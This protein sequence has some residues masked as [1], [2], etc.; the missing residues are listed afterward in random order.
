[1]KH[2]FHS[3]CLTGRGLSNTPSRA[4]VL[5]PKLSGKHAAAE[6]ISDDQCIRIPPR[7]VALVAQGIDRSSWAGRAGFGQFL[8]VCY[9][10]FRSTALNEARI[11]AS[12]C[13]RGRRRGRWLRGSPETNRGVAALKKAPLERGF[14]C[15]TKAG[16][17]TSV[18]RSPPRRAHPANASGSELGRQVAVDFEADADLDEGRGCPGHGFSS[19]VCVNSIQLNH[20]GPARKV[21]ASSRPQNVIRTPGMPCGT[22]KETAPAEAG[23]AGPV[24][25]SEP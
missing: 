19:L 5:V 20:L 24:K 7:K 11:W 4:R 9:W 15:G 25:G 16:A 1:M 13:Q 23:P 21:L 14:F 22:T 8:T 10:C 17:R 2:F 6:P 18:T 12:A 3:D